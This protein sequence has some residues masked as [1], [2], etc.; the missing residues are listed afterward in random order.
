MTD[1]ERLSSIDEL[2]RRLSYLQAGVDLPKP[3]K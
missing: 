1:E 2:R 3:P